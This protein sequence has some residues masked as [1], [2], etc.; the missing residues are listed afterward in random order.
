MFVY[1]CALE[2]VHG[3]EIRSEFALQFIFDRFALERRFR[4][5]KTQRRQAGQQ[6]DDCRRICPRQTQRAPRARPY[7]Q[8]PAN[9]TNPHDNIA[10]EFRSSHCETAANRP[11]TGGKAGG[12]HTAGRM[13]CSF[14][15]RSTCQG[16]LRIRTHGGRFKQ[17]AFVA[18][19]HESGDAFLG[20][21]VHHAGGD[22][23]IV[24]HDL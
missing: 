4:P 15:L 21:Q 19:G 3:L 14:A 23:K 2:V 16:H 5:D 6:G 12:R 11:V 10:M 7:P 1:R 20:R 13:V 8:R 17:I 24:H 9:R 22:Q 18:A